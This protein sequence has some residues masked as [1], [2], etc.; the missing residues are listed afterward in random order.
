MFFELNKS[1]TNCL[2]SDVNTHPNLKIFE[3]FNRK[4]AL[5]RFMWYICSVHR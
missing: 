3:K 5:L 1:T 2:L 4:L